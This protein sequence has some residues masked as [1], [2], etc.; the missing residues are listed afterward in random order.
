MFERKCQ[1]GHVP[2]S[3]TYCI[4]MFISTVNQHVLCNKTKR[5]IL[6][7]NRF[8]DKK[9]NVR[10]AL[11]LVEYEHESIGEKTN[12][13]DWTIERLIRTHECSNIS[14]RCRTMTI[15][16]L[17][18][19]ALVCWFHVLLMSC[20]IKGI[21][22]HVTIFYIFSTQINSIINDVIYGYNFF[23]QFLH[24]LVV[25]GILFHIR[26]YS[27]IILNIVNTLAFV[28]LTDHFYLYSLKINPSNIITDNVS[29]Y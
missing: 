24:T 7:S 20:A 8:Y 6:F 15:L 4:K 12:W 9:R 18:T 16:L 1:Q 21:N 26:Q 14:L 29:Q 27:I 22:N 25:F 23:I 13:L 10:D 5:I 17:T 19:Y 28:I 2:C 11:S 3:Q